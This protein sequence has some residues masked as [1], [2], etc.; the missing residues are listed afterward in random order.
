M[1]TIEDRVT[2]IRSTL[3]ELRGELDGCILLELEDVLDRLGSLIERDTPQ[4]PSGGK[5]VKT[6]RREYACIQGE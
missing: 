5:P 1:V 4:I 3:D 6:T 2:T